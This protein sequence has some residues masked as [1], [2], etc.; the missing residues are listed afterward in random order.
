MGAP[1][2][3]SAGSSAQN[4]GGDIN[5]LLASIFGQQGSGTAP[6]SNG[7]SPLT[8]PPQAQPQPVAQ[9]LPV[10][11]P[12]LGRYGGAIQPQP[13]P[14]LAQPQQGNNQ[15]PAWLQQLQQGSNQAGMPK[16]VQQT[17][18]GPGPGVPA[19]VFNA[20]TGKLTP[21]K[22]GPAG[23][24]SA[25][26]D[27]RQFSNAPDPSTI[28]YGAVPQAA[29]L[30]RTRRQQPGKVWSNAQGKLVPISDG[31]TPTSYYYGK[32]TQYTM[33]AT[34]MVTP[35][36]PPNSK[37]ISNQADAARNYVAWPAGGLK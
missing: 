6:S 34:G 10:Q 8:P 1:S 36:A 23:S 21:Y 35:W 20:D 30:L 16:P 18:S 13:M 17:T 2:T 22:P 33:D 9:T 32:P 11:Q 7:V 24:I 29:Q 27:S 31:Y 26:G 19:Y 5:A 4:S 12:D 28:V 14:Q 37:F 25:P 3:G 15:M